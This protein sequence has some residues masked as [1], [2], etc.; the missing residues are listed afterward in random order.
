MAGKFVVFKGKNGEDYFR[1]K[2]GNGEIILSSEGYKSRK[3]CLNGIESVRKNSQDEARFVCNTAKDG[4]MY[5]KLMA[6]NGQE[7]GRSQ[8]Y[9]SES[10]CKNGIKSVAKNAADAA[11]VEEE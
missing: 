4:R 10:G 11:V 5:F 8:M 9:K 7:I 3:S 2:A 1:L 6:T